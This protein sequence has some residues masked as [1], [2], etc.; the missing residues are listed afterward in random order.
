MAHQLLLLTSTP[1]LVVPVRISLWHG[2]RPCQGGA[3]ALGLWT[4]CC[5]VAG[6][7][8]MSSALCGCP[9]SSGWFPGSNEQQL[10]LRFFFFFDPCSQDKLYKEKQKTHP[11]PLYSIKWYCPGFGGL[12]YVYNQVNYW[13]KERYPEDKYSLPVNK[14]VSLPY[15]ILPTVPLFT[16]GIW[17]QF[18]EGMSLPMCVGEV[19]RFEMTSQPKQVDRHHTQGHSNAHSTMCVAM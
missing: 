6:Q 19:K 8:K 15:F 2:K 11:F 16:S 10:L 17:H 1:H 3:S 4:G 13:I 12:I 14:E 5:W 7:N 9:E 18:N